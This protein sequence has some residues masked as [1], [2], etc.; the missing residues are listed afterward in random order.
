MC[1]L[2]H[3]WEMFQGTTVPTSS[4]DTCQWQQARL[5]NSHPLQFLCL[6]LSP[7]LP[8]DLYHLS[9]SQ[10]WA[11]FIPLP[12]EYQTPTSHVPLR[13]FNPAKPLYHRVDEDKRILKSLSWCGH[14]VYFVPHMSAL[15]RPQEEVRKPRIIS[16]LELLY[17]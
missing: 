2:S 15:F 11:S 9:P 3:E 13:H 6:Q 17:V 12:R 14:I 10:A 16:F 5:K 4:V 1:D 7:C 8:R